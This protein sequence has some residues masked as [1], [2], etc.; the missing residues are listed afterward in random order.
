MQH[1]QTVSTSGYRAVPWAHVGRRWMLSKL[2]CY[3]M[4]ISVQLILNSLDSGC[5]SWCSST[6]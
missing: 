2:Q 5:C 4:E 6:R 3:N 1:F